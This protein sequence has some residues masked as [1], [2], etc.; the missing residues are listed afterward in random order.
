MMLVAE[1]KDLDVTEV[2]IIIQIEVIN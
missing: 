2:E 1:S